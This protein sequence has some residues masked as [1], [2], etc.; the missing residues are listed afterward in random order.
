M[1]EEIL[2]S[3]A[4]G[5]RRESIAVWRCSDDHPPRR[6]RDEGAIDLTAKEVDLHLFDHGGSIAEL[7]VE[8]APTVVLRGS[9]EYTR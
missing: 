7:V 9:P 8:G 5:A 2:F 6:R 4:G 1:L 3:R